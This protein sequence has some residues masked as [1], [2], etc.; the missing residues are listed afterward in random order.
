LH[1]RLLRENQEPLFQPNDSLVLAALRV[2]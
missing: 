2:P 1:V